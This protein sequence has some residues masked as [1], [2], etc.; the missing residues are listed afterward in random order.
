M[1]LLRDAA[2][3]A[4]INV[5]SLLQVILLMRSYRLNLIALTGSS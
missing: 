3:H 4:P 2:N 1:A 5:I